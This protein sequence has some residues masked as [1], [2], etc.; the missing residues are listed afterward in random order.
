LKR[1]I[2]ALVRAAVDEAA[3]DTWLLAGE[4]SYT[5]ADALDRIDRAAS[6]LRSA[7][8]GRGD[9]VLV[10]ARNEP[11]Y[12]LTW[13]ALMDVGAVQ[14]PVNPKSSRAELAG[15]VTQVAPRLIVTD[16]ELAPM[17]DGAALDAG[18]RIGRIGVAELFDA[19]PDG[20]APADL[21]EHD[22][23]VMIP[24]SGTTGR[25][26][27]VMQT[28]LAYVMAG[29]G[30]P[31][32]LQITSADRLMT[33]LPLFHINAPAYSTLGSM[34]A[35]GS[36]V[37]LSAFSARDF[38]DAARRYGATEF[39]SIGAM[40]EILMRQ[41]ARPDDAD[42]PIRLC[43]TGPSPDRERQLEVE[44]RF[45]FEIVCGYALSETPYGLVWRHGTRPYGSLGSARQHPDLGH[46]NDARVMDEGRPVAAGEVGELELRNPAIMRG[47]Y[48]MPEATAEVVVNRWL[49][50]G[51]LVRDDGDETY[52][53]VGRKKEVIRRRGE[54]L[55]PAEVEAALERQPDVAEA[56]V[57]AVPSELSED[58]VKA[59]VTAAPERSVDIAALHAFAGEHL[60]R[61]K[62]PR[63]FEVVAELPHTPTGRLAKHQLPVERTPEEV[64]MT[65]AD[66][67]DKTDRDWVHSWI[68]SSTPDRITV[69]G[70]DLPGELMGR[71]TLT[72]LA[73]LLV[74]RREATAGERRILDA[75]LVS[76]ADHGLTP[77][78]LAA[79]L[80]YT[81]A[82]EAIQGAV[83]AGL[84]GAGSVFL[85]P[86]GDTARFLA[87]A[88]RA[89]AEETADD[90]GLRRIA[91]VVVE[92]RRRG[93]GRVPGLGHPIH[94][95]EDPRVP[96]LYALAAE[97]GTLGPHLRLLRH[98]ADVHRETTGKALPINGA[99][100]AGAALADV[101]VP[102]GS[103]R[104][105]AL[106][107]RTAGL[108]GQLAEEA[109]HPIGRNLAQEMEERASG[110]AD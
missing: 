94:R 39:N 76:L 53:F 40:L 17:V 24:T 7:G 36:L 70:R 42:N 30:F 79:R 35:R 108:V 8:V 80:T 62:I 22:V 32:W 71:L 105:F 83:A 91:E 107:A 4:E 23:A 89:H 106:I 73:F 97:A 81:G 88:L 84:L 56:A 74:T 48:E 78:A 60:A 102:P 100:A 6:T 19:A 21:D 45:G 49:R 90:A 87:D 95:V 31:H 101:G 68:G 16:A 99:G 98:V 43:Y 11:A 69:A 29:E 109:E 47:Y 10:T 92:E 82:P 59:Y 41:P 12:L 15:F 66:P 77:S 93:G 1:T 58:D 9:R 72:E 64:D 57:I 63:Y 26:K 33:S 13:L 110:Q 34:A 103:V 85:G 27:L 104:G 50:T 46:V 14:V 3:G 67:T 51:D 18:S 65:G 38:L 61:F 37:L 25:S 20:R 5:Y 96:R 55:S 54:N 75:V 52:T 44:A 2:P 28:H 86:A